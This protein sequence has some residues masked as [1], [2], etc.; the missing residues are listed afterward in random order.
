MKKTELSRDEIETTARLTH[1]HWRRLVRKRSGEK[2]PPEW[3]ELPEASRQQYR[4][5]VAFVEGLITEKLRQK[6]RRR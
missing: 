3:D 1:T 2:P 4:L 5:F 6:E